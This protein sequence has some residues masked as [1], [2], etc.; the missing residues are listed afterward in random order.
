MDLIPLEKMFVISLTVIS[1]GFII[2]GGSLAYVFQYK[3]IYERE[4]ASGFSLFVCLTLLIANI[5]RIMF[6]FGKRFELALVTQSVVMLISMILML[7]ISVRTN[8]K[9]VYKAQRASVWT[10]QLISHFWQWNDLS[11]YFILIIAFIIFSSI[12]TYLLSG[13]IIYVEALGLTALLFEACLGFP[14]LKQNCSRR[15]TSGMSIGMLLVWA[16]GDCGKTAYFI[17]ENSPAQ[18]WLCGIIQIIIDLSIML[19]V[20]CFGKKGARSQVQ[21]PQSDP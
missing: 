13:Y 15:S 5:L 14:Q 9:H 7:E 11:S 12:L 20:Y 18:F 1:K 6:W 21:L 17:Y 4:D 2:F 3:K 19:Q 8:R 10:G 16:V